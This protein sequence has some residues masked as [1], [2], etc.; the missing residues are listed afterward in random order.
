MVQRKS[1]KLSNYIKKHPELND[2]DGG[3]LNQ[4]PNKKGKIVPI[5]ESDT[6]ISAGVYNGPLELGMAKWDNSSL[7][8]FTETVD[9]FFNDKG[10]KNSIKNSVI[11]MFNI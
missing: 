3:V 4:F 2:D 11:Y 10:I 1:K 6:S 5:K 7:S 8:P 9:N